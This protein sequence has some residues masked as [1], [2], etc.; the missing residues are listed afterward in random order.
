MKKGNICMYPMTELLDHLLNLINNS[1]RIPPALLGYGQRNGR[2]PIHPGNGPH[3][4]LKGFR[5]LGHILK[6][7]QPAAIVLP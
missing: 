1:Q 4:A 5:D 2:P 7:D 6:A 3:I